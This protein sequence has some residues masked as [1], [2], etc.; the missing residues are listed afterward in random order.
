MSLKYSKLQF[1]NYFFLC[2]SFAKLNVILPDEFMEAPIAVSKAL[3]MKNNLE[4]GVKV[5]IAQA[6]KINSNMKLNENKEN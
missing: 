2:S 4:D 5:E 1:S 6:E 3:I